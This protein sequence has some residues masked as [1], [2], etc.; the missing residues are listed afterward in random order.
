MNYIQTYDDNGPTLP[1]E[2]TAWMAPTATLIGRVRLGRDV[3]LWYGATVRGDNEPITLGDGTNVQENAVLHVDPGHPLDVG[4]NVTVGHGAILHGCRIGNGCVI[5]MGAIV[6]NG[7]RVGR[8]CLIAA[9]A[10]VLEKTEIPEGSLVA[11][12]PATVR[13]VLS[14]EA[15]KGL[16]RGAETYRMKAPKLLAPVTLD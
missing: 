11:G 8:N 2:G 6:M 15:R 4:Q 14:D 9:G 13:R 7:A 16:L 1:S 12:S 3:S 5:G 10:V